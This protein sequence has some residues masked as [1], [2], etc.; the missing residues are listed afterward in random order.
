MTRLVTE[1]GK[2]AFSADVMA[3]QTAQ[4]GPKLASQHAHHYV[5]VPLPAG[6]RSFA[7]AP[8]HDEASGQ[9]AAY[10][11]MLYESVG[12]ERITKNKRSEHR[13]NV[14]Q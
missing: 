13:R 8:F 14:I 1:R 10:R 9:V 7:L 2:Q 5:V 12:A 3:R 6:Q 4:P 11:G